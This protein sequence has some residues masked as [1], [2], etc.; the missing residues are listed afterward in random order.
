M[1]DTPEVVGGVDL[2]NF[3]PLDFRVPSPVRKYSYYYY[4]YTDVRKRN[5]LVKRGLSYVDH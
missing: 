4:Y 3:P 1:T 5:E 2:V